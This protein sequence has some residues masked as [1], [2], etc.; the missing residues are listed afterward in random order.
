M[1]DLITYIIVGLAGGAIYALIASGLAVSYTATGIF[2]FAYGAIAYVAAMM[3]YQLNT[4]LGWNRLLVFILTI[5]I[6]C[7]LFGLVL[8]VL[9][10]RPLAR[11]TDEAKIMC[12]VGLLVAL[13]ALTNYIVLGGISTFDWNLKDPSQANLPPGIWRSP[14]HVHKAGNIQI[15]DNQIIVIIV[16]V[17]VAVSLWYILRRTRLGLQMRAVVDRPDLAALRGVN[18]AKTSAVAWIIGTVLAGLAGVVGAPILQSLRIEV[19]NLTMF[20]A[21]AAV[22][23]GRLRSVPLAFV[24]GIL[25][26]VVTA[27]VQ[28]YLPDSVRQDFPGMANAVPFVLLFVGLLWLA[29]D[30]TRR[31]GVVAIQ[32]PPTNW[33][34]DLPGWRVA[35]PWAIAVGLFI[36]WVTFILN[37]FWLGRF[38][39][40]LSFAVVFMSFV[41]VTGQG[42]MVSLAQ[43]S[44]V[45]VAAMLVGRLTVAS[46]WPWG[47]ALIA[48]MLAAAAIGTI[49]ALPALRIGGLPLAL[50]T[51]A[52]GFVGDEILFRW[53]WL[54]RSQSGWLISQPKLGPI[55]LSDRRTY[56]FTMM[57][58][59]ALL[60]LL[61]RNLQRSSSGRTIT[62]VRN[63]EAAA[64]T[65]GLSIPRTKLSI[66][67]LSAAVAGLGGVLVATQNGGITSVNFPTGTTLAW[68]AIVVLF[69]IRKPHGAMLAGVAFAASDPFFNNGFHFAFFPSFL[70]W[71]GLG[72]STATSVSQ[73]LFG[74]GAIQ[75]ARQPDG[76]LAIT[77]MQNRARRDKR[78]SKA[79]KPTPAITI[80][81]RVDPAAPLPAN[82]YVPDA[83]ITFALRDVRSGYGLV[84]VLRG[85]TLSVPKGHITAVLGPNGA[86]KSTTC[87]TAAGRVAAT[88]GSIEFEGRD[89]TKLG[90]HKRAQMGIVLAPEA[91][92]IFPGL[93]VRENLQMWLPSAADRE[94][95]YERFPIL[96]ERRNLS[97]GN[98]S[99]G[100]QQIL[101]LASLLVNPPA[102]L[103]ADEPSLGLAPLIVDQIM[104]LFVELKNRGTALLLVEEKARDLLDIADSVAVLNLG[105]ITWYGPRSE[106]DAERI[107]TEYLG[108]LA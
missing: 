9:V 59:L 57:I 20:I 77:A 94:L 101:T 49:V 66:F 31:G 92:G 48:G 105:R 18:D 75:L 88:A 45:T 82:L 44:F 10:F 8:N 35:L 61:V 72:S 53:Q 36:I 33:T 102:V 26:G 97:S 14:A 89:I 46:G 11:A 34:S 78:R 76:V 51:L 37:N 50:A 64:S 84:E 27:L 69:G 2:N 62:A 21:A 22:V 43:A 93:T 91:R 90:A 83:E 23:L 39:T 98:L 99:G 42:G 16:A 73:I 67:A 19:F 74:L 7:P 85:V 6:F 103:I 95:V 15:N 25:L 4:G 68:L 28:S 56:I 86:G 32:T 47:L 12:T 81:E 55:E 54:R 80:T 70:H 107:A 41:I 87:L 106:V 100:E 29:R 96:G 108:V 104:G 24:G 60:A 3:F 71:D 30:R 79:A 65:S 52:L 63:S 40:G 13:P 5:V 17:I 38:A 58:I 1:E